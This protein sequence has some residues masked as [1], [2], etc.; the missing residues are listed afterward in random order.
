MT[1]K[2]NIKADHGTI[3]SAIIRIAV[4]IIVGLVVLVAGD[5]IKDKWFSERAQLFYTGNY[6]S[7]STSAKHESTPSI[8]YQLIFYIAL[9]HL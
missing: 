6:T 1:P 9:H 3:K 4:G 5:V 7:T 2:K 8:G